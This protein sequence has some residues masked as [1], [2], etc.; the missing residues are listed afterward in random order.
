MASKEAEKY[1]LIKVCRYCTKCDGYGCDEFC[2]DWLHTINAFDAGSEWTIQNQTLNDM[3][4]AY[5]KTINDKLIS[6]HRI[7]G[8]ILDGTTN[9]NEEQLEEFIK[10][11]DSIAK[12]ASQTHSEV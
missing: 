11:I 1:G 4:L 5:V 3:Q 9:W 7:C 12:S 6:I 10:Q 8:M 2:E